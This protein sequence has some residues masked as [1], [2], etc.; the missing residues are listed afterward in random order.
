MLKK[1]IETALDVLP[2]RTGLRGSVVGLQRSGQAITGGLAT[3]AAPG[4]IFNL[5]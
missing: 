4:N 5:P 3:L 1:T 2:S